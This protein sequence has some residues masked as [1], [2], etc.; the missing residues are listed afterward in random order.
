MSKVTHTHT[1]SHKHMRSR[2]YT[3]TH[4]HVDTGTRSRDSQTHVCG[5]L[6]CVHPTGVWQPACPRTCFRSQGWKIWAGCWLEA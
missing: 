2:A 5:S 6:T 4:E 3:Q 1:H